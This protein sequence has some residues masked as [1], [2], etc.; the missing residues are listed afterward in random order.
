M[1]NI[2]DCYMSWPREN[3]EHR[4]AQLKRRSGI[5]A[6]AP[7]KSELGYR[8]EKLEREKE[9]EKME[10]EAREK[11]KYESEIRPTQMRKFIRFKRG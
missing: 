11:T 5:Y 2:C 7:S 6:F 8:H 10:Q 4:D 9:L 3:K 1:V